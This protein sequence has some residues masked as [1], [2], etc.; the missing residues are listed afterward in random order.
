MILSNLQAFEAILSDRIG[1][2]GR[3]KLSEL[4]AG[5]SR[6]EAA[7]TFILVLFSASD[8]KVILEQDGEDDVF[9]VLVG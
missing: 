5:L 8:G 4:V 3:L 7:R 1:T 9:V 6:L 2:L